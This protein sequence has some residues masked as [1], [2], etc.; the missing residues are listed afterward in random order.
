MPQAPATIDLNALHDVAADDDAR[1]SAV[2]LA[3]FNRIMCNHRSLPLLFPA[4]ALIIIFTL[5]TGAPV[6]L[7]GA[8]AAAVFAIWLELAHFARSY[9]SGRLPRD[10]EALSRSLSL[11]YWNANIVWSAMIF[12]FWSPENDPQNF[13]LLLLF[14][15]H[16]SVATATTSYDWRIYLSTTAP[17]TFAIVSA[18]VYA[19]TSI[20]FAVAAMI[21]LVYLFVIGIARQVISQSASAVAL[22]LDHDHLIRDLAAAKEKSDDALAHAEAANRRLANSER[23]FRALV[24]NAF[25][26][27]MMTDAQGII[28]FATEGV[29]RMFDT[30]QEALRGTQVLDLPVADMRDDAHQVF[31]SIVSGAGNEGHFTG[32]AQTTAGRRIW[33]DA[34]GRNMLDDGSV[35][36][37]VL[38]IREATDRKR[39]DDELKMHLHVLEA[40]A[41]GASIEDVLTTLVLA[42]ENLHP[43][44]KASALI[45]DDQN[46]L[47]CAAAPSLPDFY[48]EALNPTPVG[49]EVGS[50]GAAAHSGKRVIVSDIRNHPYWAD[51]TDLTDRAGLR[52]CW[53]EPVKSLDGT[54]L[55]TLAMYYAEVREPS[56]RELAFI[57]TAAQLAAIAI[58]RRRAERRLAEALRNAEL[59]NHSK[60]QFLANMSHELR[61]PL[62]AII[63]FSEM[64]REEMFGP[65]GCP[66]YK[67][68]VGDIH[69]SGRHLL[70]LINDILDISKIEAGQMELDETWLDL[71][72]TIDWSLELVQPKA[73]EHGVEILREPGTPP[74][75]FAD[76]RAIKQILLNLVS[77]AIKF[78]ERGGKVT[79]GCAVEE[80]GDLAIRISDNGIGIEG[81]LIEKV[82]EPFG[83]AE[84]PMAR[85]HGGTGLGLPITKSLAEMHGGT[86]TLESVFGEG[87]TVTVHMPASRLR[88][89]SPEAASEN[90]K[91]GRQASA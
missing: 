87:T 88:D 22:R 18:A 34:T 38:N 15:A 37:I 68:Y 75:L 67:D 82:L 69:T 78:T 49:P 66:E 4:I 8:W 76:E 3:L 70:S 39:A 30:T 58:E 25:D 51:Y 77:N 56:Q 36:A 61:T 89:P 64:M 20:Y 13:F 46:R 65:L 60:T 54:V 27:V 24:D 80:N 14:T 16:L 63:G 9:F 74:E 73:Q 57:R 21:F 42:M 28:V 59:A 23:R 6:W 86:M 84:G 12:M 5:E 81:H 50:C 10:P 35:N 52:A 17:V 1:D 43:G 53:S 71:R 90:E 33:V 31:S 47:A 72:H 32:W 11:R 29:A 44:M 19:G 26:G 62:N 41:T 79:V 48:I 91:G 7:T 83:Q 55:G 40:L 85:S 2:R 45:L